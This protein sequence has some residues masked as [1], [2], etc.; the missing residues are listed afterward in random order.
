MTHSLI[1]PFKGKFP[2]ILIFGAPGVGKGTLCKFLSGSS[3]LFHLSSGDIF[4]GVAKDSPAGVIV[5][6]Y[7]NQGL[8]LPDDVTLA[9]WDHYVQGLIAT[10]KYF[11]K[12]QYLLLDGIPRTKAQAVQI[13]EYVNVAAVIVL[14]VSNTNELIK[15]LKG[16]ALKEKRIDDADEK[17]LQTRMDVYK[18]ETEQ[19][20]HHYDKN[21]IHR[22]NADQKPLEVVRDTLVSL[23]RLLAYA[24]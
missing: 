17:I 1:E 21:I 12:E 11:P 4:R 22:I 16:R 18:N 19:V 8:L 5:A 3:T 9:I 7:A 20:L 24:P 13:D 2:S 6:K 15:R 14:E 23:S 10:N